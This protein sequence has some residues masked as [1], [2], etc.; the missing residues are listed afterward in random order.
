MRIFYESDHFTNEI[1]ER[2]I[3][4][5]IIRIYKR[6]QILAFQTANRD[7]GLNA[8]VV[9]YLVDG[10]GEVYRVGKNGHLR[11]RTNSPKKDHDQCSFDNAWISP[12]GDIY[13]T[14]YQG[15]IHRADGLQ[16]E[17]I[18]P[19]DVSNPVVWLQEH[20]WISITENH[21][22]LFGYADITR[23]QI[24]TLKEMVIKN[25]TLTMDISTDEVPSS[26]EELEAL[27]LKHNERMCAYRRAKV[28]D[29]KP[30]R[31]G[32]RDGD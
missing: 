4:R 14:Y 13:P 16:E 12:E 28:E 5:K 19:T 27:L 17:G 6:N 20:G 9:R 18:M 8:T 22:L 26:P 2:A 1:R 7:Y 11:F 32:F 3:E 25:G 24:A 31:V 29:S 23:E 15:H 30:T 10:I 21:L